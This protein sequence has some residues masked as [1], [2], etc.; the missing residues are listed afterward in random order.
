LYCI[1][2]KSSLI[3]A[4]G[5]CSKSIVINWSL[6]Q[7][8]T[9]QQQLEYGVRYFDMRPGYLDYQDDFYFVHGVHGNAIRGMLI[10]MRDFLSQ[11]SQEII[12]VDFNHFHQFDRQLHNR[13]VKM[14]SDIFGHMLLQQEKNE[15]SV[16]CTLEYMWRQ[17]R[18]V[19]LMYKDETTCSFHPE[20]LLAKQFIFSPWHNTDSMSGLKTRLNGLLEDLNHPYQFNVFQAI[21]T[22][23]KS[24]VA[25]NPTSTLRDCLVVK[26][27]SGIKKWLDEVFTQC[28]QGVNIVLCDFICD[29]KLIES[30]LKLNQINETEPER[31]EC[32]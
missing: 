4:L 10:S 11:N 2:N 12:I 16:T 20:L 19:F 6:C 29:D 31:S 5:S 1:V 27:N 26:C 25:L 18:Q 3:K 7:S 23:R 24:T 13:F 32:E 9:I 22:A 28:K 15:A 30:I 14:I 8:L 21:L 17:Q